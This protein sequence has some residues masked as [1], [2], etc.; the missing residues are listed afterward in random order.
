VIY[1]LEIE[2]EINRIWRENHVSIFFRI[3]QA[4]KEDRCGST[5]REGTGKKMMK[6]IQFEHAHCIV[7]YGSGMGSFTRELIKRKNPDTKLFLIENNS[8]FYR[9]LKREFGE[10]EGVFLIFDSA[11]K[12]NT[13]LKKYGVDTA[14]YIVSGLPFTSLP[15][16]VS[17]NIMEATQ[18]AIGRRGKFITFQYSM[19]KRKFFSRYFVIVGRLLEFKN[20]PPAYVL[21]MRN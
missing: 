16:G 18:R 5:K 8:V 6:P 19:A 15:A 7:E 10:K 20:L 17:K 21:V 9:R 14:D 11:E 3:Y 13:Y 2:T 1:T 4:P 12:I